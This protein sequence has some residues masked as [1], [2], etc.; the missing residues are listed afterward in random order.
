MARLSSLDKLRLVRKGMGNPAS[1]DV[2]DADLAIYLWQASQE[3]TLEHK[4]PSL[5]TY[6]D[7]TTDGTN[8][9]YTMSNTD[10]LTLL[11]PGNNITNGYPMKLMDLQWDRQQGVYVGGGGP[12]YYLPVSISGGTCIIRLRPMPG[13]GIV[14]RIPYLKVPTAPGVD[15]DTENYS[16]V[17]QTFDLTEVSLAVEIGLQ[18]NYDKDSAGKEAGLGGR[19]HM[20]AEKSL[21]HSAFYKNKLAIF[22]QRISRRRR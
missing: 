9:D 18:A 10:V 6:E 8:T 17:P 22:H 11:Y 20:P 14:C 4:F 2:S 13:A 21:P 12:F 7:L 1:G 16:D 3:L 15:A 5:A 19:R